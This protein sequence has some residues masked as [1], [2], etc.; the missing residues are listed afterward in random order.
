MIHLI[1]FETKYPKYKIYSDFR[2]RILKDEQ[3]IEN[4]ITINNIIRE[5][6]QYNKIYNIKEILNNDKT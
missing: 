4:G 5:H 6:K 3:I 2:E 1:T